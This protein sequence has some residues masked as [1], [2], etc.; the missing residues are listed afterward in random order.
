MP[1]KNV[2]KA[3]VEWT[4][5]EP[6][7]YASSPIAR[8][9]FC[10]A[11]G[12]PLSFDYPDNDRMD[13]TIGSFDDPSVF[14]PKRHFGAESLHERWFDTSDLPR[15]RADAYEPLVK[16]WKEKVGKLPE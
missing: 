6:D 14:E 4:P 5:R 12:T 11:C 3:D 16:R 9:G 13:L 7:Y 2:A 1:F 10:K 8:R 15:D